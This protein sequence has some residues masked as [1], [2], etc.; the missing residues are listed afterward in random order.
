MIRVHHTRHREAVVT[1]ALVIP[2]VAALGLLALQAGADRW[3]GRALWPQELGLDGV[4]T[5]VDDPAF[6]ASIRNSALVAALAVGACLALGWPCARAVARTRGA[7][8]AVIVGIVL[9]PLIIPQLALGSGL[10]S[11]MLRLGLADTVW[12][13]AIAHLPYVLG[14]VVLALVPAFTPELE[15]NEEAA[16]VM[17]SGRVNRLWSVTLPACRAS[18]V[19]AGAFG[20]AVSWGQY[21]TSLAVGGGLPLFPLIAVPYLRSD[22]QVGAVASIVLILPALVLI[23]A[24]GRALTP[25]QTSREGAL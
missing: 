12:G 17:G 25:H 11:W 23:V 8:R 14:Y 10:A 13:V 4:R 18:L 15:R 1:G 6:A 9:A 7:T 5:V 3:T 2:V 22:P 20:L 21:G 16:T 19:L 24:A